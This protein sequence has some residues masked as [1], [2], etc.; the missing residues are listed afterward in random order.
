MGKPSFLELEAET[1]G[2]SNQTIT[3]T[4]DSTKLPKKSS[5]PCA[6]DP[7]AVPREGANMGSGLSRSPVQP[8]HISQLGQ[9]RKWDTQALG[10]RKSLFLPRTRH[11]LITAS[12]SKPHYQLLLAKPTILGGGATKIGQLILHKA[13]PDS[14]S[15]YP[16]CFPEPHQE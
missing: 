7:L 14:T 9:G 13:I 10:A 12:F 1:P 2:R 11:Y 3:N 6:L 5:P 15:Q 4:S 8:H 16:L